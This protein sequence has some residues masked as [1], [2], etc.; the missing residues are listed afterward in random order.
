M[1]LHKEGTLAS[2]RVDTLRSL[3]DSPATGAALKA[4]LRQLLEANSDSIREVE[5]R[6]MQEEER[7]IQALRQQREKI[8]SLRREMA[9]KDAAL[10]QLSEELQTKTKDRGETQRLTAALQQA[11]NQLADKDTELRELRLSV[12]R[13]V[14]DYET[15]LADMRQSLMKERNDRKNEGKLFDS[16]FEELHVSAQEHRILAEKA[17]KYQQLAEQEV[18]RIQ[19]LEQDRERQR[20]EELKA[21]KMLEKTLKDQVAELAEEKYRLE[22]QLKELL[23]HAEGQEV[24]LGKM[25]DLDA[26]YQSE[27]QRA[28]ELEAE[29]QRLQ[30]EL[31][32]LSE[33]GQEGRSKAE[34]DCR[35]MKDELQRA[36]E[37]VQRQER[38]I[39]EMRVRRQED[40]NA[41]SLLKDDLKTQ[42]IEAD[43]ATARW[44]AAQDELKRVK[45]S[46]TDF[47]QANQLLRRENADMLKQLQALVEKEEQE[48]LER[49]QWAKVKMDL[50]SQ[51]EDEVSKLSEALETL[52]GDVKPSRASPYRRTTGLR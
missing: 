44:R 17:T 20:N 15:A 10:A 9:K 49:R 11:Q 35:V 21:W 3:Q 4:R 5:L 25:G 43:K 2:A 32:Q 22:S 18:A 42:S 33:T 45:E 28:D 26:L 1:A 8:E 38:T 29:V 14:Q 48:R 50:L 24:R 16:K 41:L 23:E 39:S 36:A 12:K 30:M 47:E 6:E 7:Y 27:Q 13:Q 51:R 46:L 34:E 31:A 40:Q 19:S 37:L 52:P